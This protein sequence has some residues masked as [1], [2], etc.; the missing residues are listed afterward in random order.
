MREIGCENCQGLGICALHIY[1]IL[2]TV[3]PVCTAEMLYI[4]LLQANSC[5]LYMLR[6]SCQIVQVVT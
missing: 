2:N 4:R 1:L 3:I 5:M 6:T